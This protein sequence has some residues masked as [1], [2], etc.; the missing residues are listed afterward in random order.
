V[1]D[2]QE[3]IRR[4]RNWHPP[5]DTP[6]YKSPV[7]RSP[8]RALLSLPQSES[9]M[10]GPVF[11]HGMLDPLDSD[12]IRNYAADGEAIG[13][14][15]VVHGQVQD[16]NARPVAGTLIEIWQAMP[17][18]ATATVRDQYIAAL[19]R[20]PRRRGATEDEGKLPH[21]PAR[22]LS[23][24]QQR[25]RLAAGAY[26]PLDLRRVRPAAGNAAYFEGDR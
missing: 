1:N 21:D 10:T 15:I 2:L 23:L 3:F 8:R 4:D 20:N 16:E 5:A 7:L 9:E 11:G 13:E 26:S 25:L 24:A 17:A 19:T 18:A 6:G 22:P 12:L 14:R